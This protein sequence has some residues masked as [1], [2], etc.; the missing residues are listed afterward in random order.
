MRASTS[1]T[2]PASFVFKGKIKK[3]KA[4]TLKA[5]PV[6]QRTAIVTVDQ[7][8]ESPPDL[9]GY[10]GQDITV[11]LTN[12]RRVSVGQEMI[13]H[14]T[15]WLYGDGIAV[16]SLGEE[17][18]KS[19]DAA[20]LVRGVDPVAR[21][22]ERETRQHFKDAD[23]VVFGKVMGVRLPSAR[24]KKRTGA[25]ADRPHRG[26]ISEHDPK[27][28]EAVIQVDEV[29]KGSH[30]KRQLVVRFPASTDVMWRGAPKFQVGQQGYF[31]LH[32]ARKSEQKRAGKK[33]KK[34]AKKKSSRSESGDGSAETYIAL[35]RYDFQP[36]SE[37]GGIKTLIESRS[38]REN[39]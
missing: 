1:E 18:I 17:P 6:N 23:L 11:Q 33:G 2:T 34:G 15:G 4:A 5:A 39:D 21:R 31:M 10:G 3:L 19:H 26:I 12:R 35:D 16:R 9:A 37:R 25:A 7:I 36:Y 14:S 22:A 28:R 20:M 24:E 8:I 13:F 38:S 30:K 27:W 29:H 32:K